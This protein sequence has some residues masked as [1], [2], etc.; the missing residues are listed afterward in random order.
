MRIST[1]P[2]KLFS[3]FMLPGYK[4]ATSFLK[5]NGIDIIFVDSDDDIRP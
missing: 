1:A 4:E 5:R 3:E 2:P